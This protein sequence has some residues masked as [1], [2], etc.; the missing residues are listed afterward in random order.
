MAKK[1]DK[2]EALRFLPPDMGVVGAVIGYTLILVYF[3]WK[4]KTRSQT[5][6]RIVAFSGM[7]IC[8]TFGT[9]FSFMN[10]DE[11]A[12]KGTGWL[13]LGFAL[14]A[15]IRII[16]DIKQLYSYDFKLINIKTIKPYT[17]RNTNEVFH[18][19]DERK[20]EQVRANEIISKGYAVQIE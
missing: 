9:L 12:W 3:F 1:R 7:T 11:V 10:P 4:L 16:F 19:G 5:K 6:W 8:L 14:L 18:D 13:V 15:V 17:D 20:I 2:M